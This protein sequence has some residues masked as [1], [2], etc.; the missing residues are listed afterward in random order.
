MS[1]VGG[2]VS[3]AGGLENGIIKA[4]SIGAHAIQIFGSSPRQWATR[5][6]SKEVVEKFKQAKKDSDVEAVFLHAPYLVNLGTENKEHWQKSVEAL[7]HHLQIAK[8]IEADGLI[9]HVGAVSKESTRVKALNL[10]VK[11]MKT[12]LDNVPG[13]TQLIM[14]N[15][16]GGPSKIGVT[17]DDLAIMFKKLK[18]KRIKICLDTAHAL[19]S[20]MIEKYTPTLIKKLFDEF[21]EKIGIDNLSVLHVN[22][23]KSAFKSYYDRHENIGEGYI[24]IEGFENL[25]REKRIQEK[26][27][28]LEVPGFE[29]HGPDKKNI[30]ILNKCF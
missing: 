5:M 2:H 3:V 1:C 6:P 13:R 10:A 30:Q 18:S 21:D 25:A 11:G 12:V 24:G 27:W 16:A 23:S 17:L 14:E 4:N 22:D 29:H 26:P 8:M 15:S 28:I 19:E 7:I 20:G 9:V